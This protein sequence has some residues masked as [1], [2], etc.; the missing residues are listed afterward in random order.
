MNKR[1]F[2]LIWT[3][4]WIAISV[5]LFALFVKDDKQLAMVIIFSL[6]AC[7]LF[8][9][10]CV[11]L[12]V[13]SYLV[14]KVAAWIKQHLGLVLTLVAVALVLSWRLDEINLLWTFLLAALM[15]GLIWWKW[16]IKEKKDT[17]RRTIAWRILDNPDGTRQHALSNLQQAGPNTQQRIKKAIRENLRWWPADKIALMVLD[18]G[19]EMQALMEEIL[20]QMPIEIQ[21]DIKKAI[22]EERL[23]RE[24]R[25]IDRLF[26]EENIDEIALHFFSG[27]F[28]DREYVI[29][30]IRETSAEFQ[31][32]L[33]NAI[34]KKQS[35]LLK[36]PQT[37]KLGNAF[38]YLIRQEDFAQKQSFFKIGLTGNPRKRLKDLQTSNPHL[39]H[40]WAAISFPNKAAARQKEKHLHGICQA[41]QKHGEWF[42][43]HLPEELLQAEDFAPYFN[44]PQ[45]P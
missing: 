24:A 31:R 39:L 22:K 41:W 25:G 33:E 14:R 45:H 6:V 20:P 42:Q 44:N 27:E 37:R 18:G 5:A 38:V 9:C 11:L 35:T 1:L 23:R 16:T 26:I 43:G 13:L 17:I 28:Q 29:Q 36:N 10:A 34:S 3:G 15:L 21:R 12:Y 8:F 2:V 32:R 40:L 19:A 7:V 30:K 4:A